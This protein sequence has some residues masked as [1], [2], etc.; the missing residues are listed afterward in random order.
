MHLFCL[1]IGGSKT[2][3]G[4]FDADGGILARAEGPG[5]ALS[6]GAEAAEAAIRGVWHDLV[7]GADRQS[8]AVSDTTLVAGM[9]GLGLP[10]RGDELR[11]RLGDFASVGF[12]SDGYGALVAETGGKPGA[13]ISVGTGVIG[14]RLFANGRTLTLGGWGFPA[15]DRGGGAWLGL[16]ATSGL[17]AHLDALE[18]AP[19]MSRELATSLMKITGSEAANIMDWQ[20]NGRPKDFAS[21]AP[22]LVA[23]AA[24]GDPYSHYLL[25]K[26][27]REVVLLAKGLASNKAPCD[28]AL[29]NN[30]TPAI[31]LGGGLGPTLLPVCARLEP[32][33]V[34][35]QALA[36]PVAGL[37]MIATGKAPGETRMPRPGFPGF[38]GS[39]P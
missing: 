14:M 8:V 36:D 15:G 26:A 31:A 25:E 39:R 10:G 38:A 30:S 21:L 33:M 6:L 4:L 16:Q 28:T 11:A 29:L 32:G 23:G 1:D 7:R 5:G 20:L 2:R 19:E 18:T 3:G 13:L 12:V 24:Q 27:A 17:L 35:R 9:A 22:C 37:V 34:W